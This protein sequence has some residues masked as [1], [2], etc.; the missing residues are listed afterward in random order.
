MKEENAYLSL[1]LVRK[2]DYSDQNVLRKEFMQT[3]KKDFAIGLLLDTSPSY[4]LY[5]IHRNVTKFAI[6]FIFRLLAFCRRRFL[7]DD[8]SLCF[9]LQ[10]IKSGEILSLSSFTSVLF[11]PAERS[12]LAARSDLHVW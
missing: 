5:F 1:S 2:P 11:F 10:G 12:N 7:E 6:F 9:S 8:G 4:F 3:E